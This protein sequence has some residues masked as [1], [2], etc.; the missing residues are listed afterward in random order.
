MLFYL[1]SEGL[2]YLSLFSGVYESLKVLS[3]AEK[4]VETSTLCRI[5]EFWVVLAAM[6]VFEQYVELFVSW[7]PFYYLFKCAF[8]GLL[9]VPNTKFTHVLYDGFV[10]PGVLWLKDEFDANVQPLLE[11]VVIKKVSSHC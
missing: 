6:T 5:L 7:F 10:H 4:G 11:A 8:L 3:R 1:L 2:T 9:L